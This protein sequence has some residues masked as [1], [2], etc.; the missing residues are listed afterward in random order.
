MRKAFFRSLVAVIL[1][2]TT[3]FAFAGGGQEEEAVEGKFGGVLVFARSGDAVGLDPARETDGESFYVTAQIYDTL[4]EFASGTTEVVPALA[5]S[6]DIASDGLTFTFKLVEGARFHDGTPVNAEAVVFSFER[7]LKE[8]HPYYKFGPWKY[9]GYMDM[10]SII[11]SI[12]AQFKLLKREA[13]FIANLAMDFASIVSPTAV[14][15]YGENFTNNPVGSGPFKFVSWQKDDNVVLE[16]N[17]DHWRERAYLDRLILKVVPDA[18]ARYLALQKGEVDVI[19]FPSVEDLASMEADPDIK[20]IQQAGLNVGYLALNCDKVPFN[21][22]RVRQAINYAI[23]KDEIIAGV[24]GKAGTPA[25]NPIPP[26]M[27]SYNDKIEGYEYSPEKARQ[28]LAEAG[29]PD[30]FSTN[31]W[32]MPVARPYNPNG[33]KVA[34]IMQAQLAAVGIKAEIVSYEWGT[35][36]DRTDTGEHDMALLGWTGDNGDPDNFLFV[37]LSIPAAIVPAGNISFWRNEEFNDL[38]VEAKET[39]DFNKR[40]SLYEKAQVVFH[41]DAPWVPIAHSVVTVPMKEYVKN[42]VLYPTGK[43]LFYRVWMEK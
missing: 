12:T 33:R 37:L 9:W 23:N 4:V 35:Y 27:W 28:L 34:E 41:D 15:K 7:Q 40:V 24:Y 29:Y 8:D 11:K 1:V 43:R 16:R 14:A 36:L 31:L 25:K 42:F 22:V 21:D 18:T 20:L 10:S 6:W 17:E 30:G 2:L 39:M 38:I 32:A 19:D 5:K 26:G 3:A 13:P